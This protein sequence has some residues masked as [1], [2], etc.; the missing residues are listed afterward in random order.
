MKKPHTFKRNIERRRRSKKNLLQM[1]DFVDEI[2]GGQLHKKR[3]ESLSNGAAGVMR[4]ASLSIHII[5]AAYAAFAEIVPKSGIKQ[6][7]RFLSNKGLN[8]EALTPAWARFVLGDRQ[9]AVLVLDWTDY[10]KD[11]Q[12]TL[13]AYVVTR[14]GRATPLAWKTVKKSTLK[15]RQKQYEYEFIERLHKAI[16]PQMRI[17][18]LADRGFGDQE[19]YQCLEILGWDYVIRFRG[20]ILVEDENG[21]SQPAAQWVLPNGHATMLRG[22][23]VTADRA[24]VAAVVVTQAKRMKEPWCLATSLSERKASEIVKLYGKRFT[25][26]ETFRDQKDLRFGMGLR[27]THIRSPERR[28][29]LLLLAALAQ[30]LLTLLGAASE[31]A[32]LDRLLKANTVKT[33]THSLFR[34]GT[35]WYSVIPDTREEWLKPLMEAFDKL[36]S[37]RE[38][39]NQVFDVL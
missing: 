9:E 2:F 12:T 24:E 16:T 19:L 3:V 21:I 18:L 33:R 15:D 14:H 27:A 26:E 20:N 32:G 30:A 10:E 35:Y 36:V 29:R 17:T 22:A 7:D 39:F 38:V 4:S 1:R 34:Q 13:A 37:E 28:D 25:I 6:V 31:A 5:G 11:D 8:V 23:R